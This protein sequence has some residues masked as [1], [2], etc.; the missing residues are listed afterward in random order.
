MPDQLDRLVSALSGRYTIERELGAGGM[1]TVYLARDLRHE[2]HVALKVLR[3]ELA[4]ALGPDRF[5]REI[6]IAANLTHPHILPLHDSGEADG[7]LYYVMPYIEG[8]SLRDRIKREG[9]L[10]IDEAARILREVVDALAHA[11]A[12]GVVHRDIKPDNVLLSGR[13]ALVSDFGVAKA[14]SE[15]TGRD[16]LTTAGVAL[17]T[18]SYMAPEQAAANPHIDHRA[19]IYAVGAMAYEL[20]AGQPP[21]TGAS[22]QM[23]LAAH[24]T[25]TPQPVTTHRAAVPPAMAQLVMRCLEKKAADRWQ[26]ADEL[27][28]EL[29]TFATPGGGV[30]PMGMR[31]AAE[32]GSVSERRGRWALVAGAVAVVALAAW[33]GLARSGGGPEVDENLVAVLPFRVVGADPALADLRE[34]MVDLMATF[35]TG[36]G[37]TPRSA[38][39]GTV[40]SAWR[41]RVASADADLDEEAA[42][43]LAQSIGAG[44]VL[45]G[46]VVGSESRIVLR[47]TLAP[48]GRRGEPV[49]ASVEGP[50]DSVFTLLPRF[51]GRL[52]AQ[53]AGLD[54]DQSA[55]LTTNSLPALRAYLR[56][57]VEYRRARYA[58]AVNRFTEALETDSNF[59][60]AGVGLIKANGWTG[61]ASARMNGIGQR[62]AWRNRDM[63]GV[64]DRAIVTA[65]MGSNG[66][67][68][69]DGASILRAREQ[70]VAVAEDRAEA[71]Y[72]VGDSYFHD[73]AL[74][75]LEDGLF[76]AEQAF[77]RAIAR[78]SSVAGPLQHLLFLAALR[79]DTVEV[80]RLLRLHEVAV[81]DSALASPERWFAAVAIGDTVLRDETLSMLDTVLVD[82]EYQG[83]AMTLPFI[84]D[85]LPE[86]RDFMSRADRRALG[87]EAR[88]RFAELNA[89]LAWEAGR[90]NDA[91]GALR[92]ISRSMA[93][94][95]VLAALF[96]SGDSLDGARAVR[97]LATLEDDEDAGNGF[98]LLGSRRCVAALWRLE[99]GQLDGIDGTVRRLRDTAADRDP[100]WPAT[101]HQVCADVLEA[102]LAQRRGR[103]DAGELIGRLDELLLTVPYRGVGWANLAVARL[104]EGEAEYTRAAAAARRHL[105]YLGYTPFLATHMRESG[106][107]AELAG[108][109]ER[110]IDAYAK[111]LA[112]R[113]D[114]EPSVAGEVDEVR[115]ALARL[116][117]ERR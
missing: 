1:A 3:P 57:Q 59:A 55:S 31:P 28:R 97:E 26:S 99:H 18:P 86:V 8:E 10:P 66:P 22:P 100:E 45:T 44:L 35:L 82:I 33:F 103:S 96:W 12:H 102:A 53:S 7:F 20:L 109:R 113:S 11:H 30:T 76:R 74:L 64:R 101:P 78:D 63:L 92:P 90:P 81:G 111:Y 110:A 69:D 36:E 37:G 108:E 83:A 19:D 104:L 98:E 34:G 15:A 27:L 73:G 40:I 23:V 39:P 80:R 13:H 84:I 93:G 32:A 94:T 58:E 70:A 16:K 52:L 4:A 106:R 91:A 107:L 17:G 49:Q 105:Y 68:P 14:V 72:F 56:G 29:E 42:R 6:R 48:V 24:V 62:A 54:A 5:L 88:E 116:T 47:G 77:R 117:A 61:T 65:V 46:A 89:F 38:D 95:R 50:T 79:E 67:E 41:G 114:P 43:A 2:R 75:G 85:R 25:E 71:W 21:F 51:V 9:E 115:Q 112:L 60:L 87:Q